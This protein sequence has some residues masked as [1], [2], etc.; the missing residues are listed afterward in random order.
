M[1]FIKAPDYAL[2]RL[3]NLG[4]ARITSLPDAWFKVAFE[5]KI[6]GSDRDFNDAVFQAKTVAASVSEPASL[7]LVG[8][9][10]AGLGLLARR[11]RNADR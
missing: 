4:F 9:G 3:S 10:L 1:F 7:A 5:D 11:R 6:I 8:L 2:P